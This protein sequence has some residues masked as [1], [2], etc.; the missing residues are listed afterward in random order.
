VVGVVN[1]NLGFGGGLEDWSSSSVVGISLEDGEHHGGSD[2]SSGVGD[3]LLEVDILT[4]WL[5]ED[6]SLEWV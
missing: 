4:V 6:L 1:E 5:V 2:I 3:V